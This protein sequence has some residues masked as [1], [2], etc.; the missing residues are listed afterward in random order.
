MI[1]NMNLVAK[2]DESD[3]LVETHK[4]SPAS[5]KNSAKNSASR[6]AAK[7]NNSNS[8]SHLKKR[9]ADHFGSIPKIPQKVVEVV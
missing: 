6:R 8:P 4:K 1:G 9:K 3:T 7:K 5:G 2:N